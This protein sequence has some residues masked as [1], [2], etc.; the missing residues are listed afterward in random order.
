MWIGLTRRF[1]ALLPQQLHINPPGHSFS[2]K[3]Y[4]SPRDYVHH[5]LPR[6]RFYRQA[7]SSKLYKHHVT[8]EYN[9]ESNS[10]GC[11]AGQ[12]YQDDN[13]RHCG[14][15]GLTSNPLLQFASHSN[16]ARCAESTKAGGFGESPRSSSLPDMSAS[17]FSPRRFQ[18]PCHW[19]ALAEGPL[20]GVEWVSPVDEIDAMGARTIP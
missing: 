8:R 15:W 1:V 12:A 19:P 3:D 10:S 5:D 17:P 18:F 4:V 13:G 16:T 14:C 9:V 7:P 2:N 20:R 6:H 11:V